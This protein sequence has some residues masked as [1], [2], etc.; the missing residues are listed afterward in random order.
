MTIELTK[1]QLPVVTSGCKLAHKKAGESI[2]PMSVITA[3]SDHRKLRFSSLN[4]RGTV[5][6]CCDNSSIER[7]KL[8]LPVV[9]SGCKLAHT[10]DGESIFPMSV[11]TTGNDDR[12]L[13]FSDLNCRGTIRFCSNNA[14]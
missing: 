6:F 2:F 9:T 3:G 8:Q 12:K 11:I 1:M 10:K 7:T 13:Q 4:C 5:G 14:N